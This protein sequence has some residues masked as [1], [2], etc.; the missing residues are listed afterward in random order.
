MRSVMS[1]NRTRKQIGS[2][3]ILPAL[4][5]AVVTLAASASAA[6]SMPPSW[7][8]MAMLVVGFDPGTGTLSVQDQA[9]H[10]SL[11][12][13]SSPY[14][15][16][17]LG[18]DAMGRPD[19]A[20]TDFAD[21]DPAQPWSV[22]QDKA[23]SRMLGWW[24]GSG[25]APETLASSIEAAFGPDAGIWIEA[26]SQSAGL[27]TY[28]AVGR[29]GVNVDN[30]TTVDPFAG[31]YTGLFGTDGSSTRWRWDYAMDH[32]TYAVPWELLSPG[33]LYSA[34]YKVYIGDAAGDELPAAVGASTFETWTWQAPAH[35]PVPEPG[36]GALLL[37]GLGGLAAANGSPRRRRP[38]PL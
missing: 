2:P 13:P 29:Y 38:L 20:A 37:G 1:S 30:T 21:Y 28:L 10:P 18:T 31:G 27:E 15:Q 3:W 32:N 5:A 34:R 35:V 17:A 19:P 11:Q 23:F 24:A 9:T 26:V 7:M 36:T 14:V 33:Q 8:P 6:Y 16:L 12:P 22:L 4:A 25:S